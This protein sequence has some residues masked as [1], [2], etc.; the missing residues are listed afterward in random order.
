MLDRFTTK[1]V[2]VKI[3]EKKQILNNDISTKLFS[4]EKEKKRKL[5]NRKKRRK[6]KKRKKEEKL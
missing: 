4:R 6:E 2:T 3:Q 5:K 1:V